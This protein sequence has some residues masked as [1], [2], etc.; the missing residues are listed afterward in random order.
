MS[1][2]GDGSAAILVDEFGLSKTADEVLRLITQRT[3]AGIFRFP[4]PSNLA[5]DQTAVP[6]NDQMDILRSTPLGFK[7][8]QQRLQPGD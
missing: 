1:Q 5:E 7:L 8:A 3:H 2:D 4:G 6:P